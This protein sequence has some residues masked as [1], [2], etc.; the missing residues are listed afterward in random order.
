MS[1]KIKKI[2][3]SALSTLLVVLILL[4]IFIGQAYLLPANRVF[5]KSIIKS[6]PLPAA[7]AN[8]DGVLMGDYFRR[9]DIAG[10]LQGTPVSNSNREVILDQ[11]IENKIAE[12]L[13]KNR[14]IG[15]SS[16]EVDEQV[17]YLQKASG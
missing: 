17:Q 15:V 6:L 5:G 10:S 9:L 16:S 1:K 4:A 3:G 13:A 14:K 2:H 11:L 12:D 7:F 8:A